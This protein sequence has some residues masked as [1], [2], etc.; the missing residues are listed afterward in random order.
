MAGD[1]G[2]SMHA[3][4]TYHDVRT[5]TMNIQQF[6][7]I[8]RGRKNLVL[9]TLLLTVI[10]A[11]VITL[12]T[13]NSYIAT[14]SLIVSVEENVPYVSFSD[15]VQLSNS[16]MI[17]QINIIQSHEVAV[18]VVDK[19]N[20]ADN[21]THQV[22]YM[23]ATEGRGA[24]RDWLAGWLLAKLTVQPSRA[25][26]VV[27]IY[28]T[29]S[30]PRFAADVANAFAE[31]YIDTRLALRVEPARKSTEWLEEQLHPL[32]QKVEGARTTLIDYQKE[33]E[34]VATDDRLDM[35]TE[36]L[37]ALSKEFVTAQAAAR[38]AVNR[39]SQMEGLL[40]EGRS[41]ETLPE[42]LGNSY[43]QSIKSELLRQENQLALAAYETGKKHP[44]YQRAKAEVQ[45]LRRKLKNEIAFYAR[46]IGDEAKLAREWVQVMEEWL[47]V[48]KQRILELRRGRDDISVLVREV[49]SAQHA[50][51]DAL[52][53]FNQ[54]T[55]ESLVRQTDVAL[56]SRARE[57][58]TPSSPKVKRNLIVAV[59]LGA[60]LG[61]GLALLFE[62]ANRRVRSMQNLSKDLGMPA[63]GELGKA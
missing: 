10:I 54:A 39:E 56:F 2:M 17:T 41:L 9:L 35:E 49:E 15:Q 50:Y 34:I 42:I 4:N 24:I 60:L 29:S 62:I 63:L 7:D 6:I 27:N 25:S 53:H 38:V 51:D 31:A 18:R 32:R 16:Y 61:I 37:Q 36:H 23:Q 28:F 11:S 59:G 55:M 20:L 45:N 5:E 13:P 3:D 44:Q 19:L 21:P 57:P 52:A 58:L 12:R 8:L 26:R 43:I 40:E 14:V 30:D 22:N 33:N 47:V 1:E 48:Q 46:S